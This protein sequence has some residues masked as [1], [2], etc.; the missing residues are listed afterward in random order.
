MLR[1]DR[2]IK[3]QIQQM[4]DACLFGAS[5]WLAWILRSD[6]D[7]SQFFNLQEVKAPPFEA[8]FWLY[9]VLIISGPL[10]LDT[11]GYYDRPALGPRRAALWPLFKGCVVVTVAL[12]MVLFFLRLA[13]QLARAV[14]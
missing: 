14:A 5:F 10:I 12:I 13:D 11:Q 9:L 3:S 6:P 8:Y 7:I 4:V 1:L 2:Q